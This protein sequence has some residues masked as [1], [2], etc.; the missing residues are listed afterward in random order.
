[1]DYM[2]GHGVGYGRRVRSF[3]RGQPERNFAIVP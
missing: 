1:V 3:S 2:I